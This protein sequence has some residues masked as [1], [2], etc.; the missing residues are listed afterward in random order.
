VPDFHLVVGNPARS[1]ALV[2]RCGQPF[3]KLHHGLFHSHD[4][5]SCP[6][7]GLRYAVDDGMVIEI[8]PPCAKARE[9]KA[10]VDA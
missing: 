1:T 3:M 6:S 7:C 9:R 10:L 8:D 2:C 5:V 4:E